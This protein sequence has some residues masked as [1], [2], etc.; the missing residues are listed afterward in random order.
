MYNPAIDVGDYVVVINSKHVEFTGK[1]WQ[2]KYYRYYFRISSV[3][4]HFVL[5]CGHYHFRCASDQLSFVRASFDI[6]VSLLAGTRAT[7]ESRSSRRRSTTNCTRPGSSRRLSLACLVTITRC[8]DYAR[9]DCEYLSFPI[10]LFSSLFHC[11]F[12]LELLIEPHCFL[13]IP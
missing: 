4:F 6:E 2:Q 10:S 8:E 11:I 7:L 13:L 5:A 9:A 3:C 1:K 12:C